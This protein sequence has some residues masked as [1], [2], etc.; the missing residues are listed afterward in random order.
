MDENKNTELEKEELDLTQEAN[1]PEETE[2]DEKDSTFDIDKV[3]SEAALEDIIEGA[4]EQKEADEEQEIELAKYA[5]DCESCATRV[6][7]ELEDLDEEGNLTCPNCE[8]TIEIDNDAIDYYLVE[9]PSEEE[10]EGNYVADCPNCE[11]VVHFKEDDVDADENIVCP[12]CGEKIHIETEVLDAYKEKDIEKSLK[13]KAV[14]KKVLASVAGVVLALALC[15]CVLYFGGNSSVVKVGGTSVPMSIYKS[16]YY[17]ENAVNYK[18]YGFNVDEKPSSQP[19]EE[20]ED[21]ETWDD[22]LKEKTNDSLKIYYSIYNAGKKEGYEISDEDKEEIDST[23]KNI[24]SYAD[25]SNLSFE[26]YMY[27]NYGLKISEKNFRPYLEL[28]EYVNSYY[29]NILSKEVTDE[30]LE[31][32][33]SENP[34]N[35]EVVSFRYFYVAVDSETTK[36]DALK[37]VEAI[38][39]AKTESEFHKLVKENVSEEDAKN[40]YAEDD[41][42]LVKDMACSNIVDRPVAAVLTDEKSA[43]G[44]TTFGLSDDETYAEVA[45]LVTPRHKDDTL[46][47]NAAINEVAAEKGQEYLENI[48]KDVE[49]KSSLGM[50]LRNFTF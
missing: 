35:Y 14:L 45:M 3:E 46:I 20:S 48:S 40:K 6:Y 19:Y 31:T 17:I 1:A 44:Q 33:Y 30:Q 4:S 10:N 28:S 41:A 47:M 49:V 2:I 23:M 21:Y 32:I 39:Q 18:S 43:A 24:K 37:T 13:K 27:S 22:F 38:A 9:K 36:E 34:E 16:V 50:I 8:E 29:K 5:A 26:E 11:A 25:A 15:F 42:T 12:A 7:F